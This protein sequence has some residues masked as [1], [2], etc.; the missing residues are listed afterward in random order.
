MYLLCFENPSPK[1]LQRQLY[2]SWVASAI[3]GLEDAELAF[4]FHADIWLE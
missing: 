1:I 3:A 4:R 2:A